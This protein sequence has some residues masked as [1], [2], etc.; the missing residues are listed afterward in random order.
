MG[1]VT[2]QAVDAKDYKKH[3]K[4]MALFN[5]PPMPED[6]FDKYR[7]IRAQVESLRERYARYELNSQRTAEVLKGAREMFK[8]S[9]R[10]TNNQ[11]PRIRRSPNGFFLD[12]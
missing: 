4:A 9:G 2:V 5:L 7:R 8:R 6:D 10:D 12:E 1:E 11:K 3:T